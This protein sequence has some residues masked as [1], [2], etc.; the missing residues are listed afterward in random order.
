MDTESSLPYLQVL[1]TRPC[2]EDSS[3]HDVLIYVQKNKGKLFV[4]A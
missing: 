4:V 2:T 1:A 3:W